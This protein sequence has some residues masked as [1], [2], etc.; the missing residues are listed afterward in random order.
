MSGHSKWANIK[1]QKEKTDAQRGKAFT[2]ITREIV[3][4]AKQGG[5]D[6]K[7]NMRLRMAIQKA[8]SVNMPME[9]IQ[10]AIKRALGATESEAYE[11]AVYEGY[12]PG[13]GAIMLD[14]LT[15][16]RNRTAGEIRYL[17]SKFGGNL[18]E[19]GCVAWMFDTR[20]LIVV[21]KEGCSL[22]EDDLMMAAL[23]AGA[24]DV[25]AAGDVYEILTEP[26]DLE[27]VQEALEAKGISILEAQVSRIP[28]TTVDLN[29]QD[30]ARAARLVEAL[31]DHDDVQ[32]VYANFD[33]AAGSGE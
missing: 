15:D 4:A 20:G 11:E 14:I 24:Q 21:Q 5:G 23:E 9:N 17:F 7:A 1:H 18:G 16:N 19:A 2:K 10:R 27:K 6:P 22:S 13:G 30:A 32:N 33:V 12:G 8:R 26:G 28:K 25:Q 3:V 31:E 29:A